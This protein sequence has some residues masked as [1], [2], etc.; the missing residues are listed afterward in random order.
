MFDIAGAILVFGEI[1][2]LVYYFISQN[3]FAESPERGMQ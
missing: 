1:V 2:F 3:Q